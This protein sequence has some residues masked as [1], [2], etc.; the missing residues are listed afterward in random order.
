MPIYGQ[1][2]FSVPGCDD[3]ESS[4][5]ARNDA[6]FNRA[7]DTL[8][9]WLIARG[10]SLMKGD[11]F[12]DRVPRVVIVKGALKD[13]EELARWAERVRGDFFGMEKEL[14]P[15]LPCFVAGECF[16]EEAEEVSGDS[17]VVSF[18]E[19]TGERIRRGLRDGTSHWGVW[20]DVRVQVSVTG[21]R[22]GS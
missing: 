20:N 9:G 19:G 15:W 8:V 2:L 16:S 11:P 5:R 10:Y 1:Q 22:R 21:R 7:W 17:I 18:P 13:G 3:L 6:R 4:L 14:G 12:F